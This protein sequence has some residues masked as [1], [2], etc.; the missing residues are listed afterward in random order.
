M[1]QLFVLNHQKSLFSAYAKD[2]SFVFTSYDAD[3]MKQLQ[4]ILNAR[5]AQSRAWTQQIVQVHMYAENH[6]QIDLT[7]NNYC[8][9]GGHDELQMTYLDTGNETDMLFVYQLRHLMNAHVYVIN[10]YDY[11]HRI[12]LLSLQGFFVEYNPKEPVE[13]DQLNYLNASLLL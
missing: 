3:K 6:I 10:D 4:K 9:L 8:A 2:K 12:P 5:Y 1:N 7:D 11:D 13:I